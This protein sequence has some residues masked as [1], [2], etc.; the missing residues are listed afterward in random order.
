[1]RKINL[2][3]VLLMFSF[4]GCTTNAGNLF[5]KSQTVLISAPEAD[6]AEPALA[7]APDGGVFVVT[8]EHGEGKAANVYL[9]KF[10]GGGKSVGEKVRINPEAGQATAWRGDPPS[11]SVGA[12]NA[13]YVVWSVRAHSAAGHG[14]N[15]NLS[16][17][18]DGGKTFAAPVKV[19]DDA[20]PAVHGM[21]SLAVDKNGRV[22]VAWLDERYLKKAEKPKVE[23]EQHKHTE[24]NREVYT[25]V[26]NDGG[27]SFLPN[28]KLAQDVCPCCKT[29]LA[30]APDNRVYVSWRQVL[31]GD[32][33]HIAV[34][35]SEDGGVNFTAPVIVSDD[36]W[37]IAACPVSGAPLLTTANNNLK[38]VWFTGGA[39]GAPGLYESESNDGGKTFA[40]RHLLSEGLDFGTPSLLP[41]EAGNY[42][43]VWG[44]EGKIIIGKSSKAQQEISQG[45]FPSAAISGKRIYVASVKKE[46]E[47]RSVWLSVAGE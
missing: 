42:K 40:P 12:D 44:A 41:D 1:M 47:R 45:E 21:S 46:N 43:A 4:V 22:Y 14:S 17:S 2:L 30:V 32:F 33:R 35:S 25:A 27:K 3:L 19:N 34:A 6:T 29:S 15:I 13:I 10:D 31:P 8:V 23:G 11:I 37:E 28:K 36:Q 9:H 18:R 20:L 38:I 26:S 16:V 7:T 39:S 24:D 5:S